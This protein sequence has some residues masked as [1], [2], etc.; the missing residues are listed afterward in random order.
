MSKQYWKNSP[1]SLLEQ[2]KSWS[3]V[4]VSARK[5]KREDELPLEKPVGNI[6]LVFDTGINLILG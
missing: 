3:P 2:Q 4:S 1:A 5:M 6:T